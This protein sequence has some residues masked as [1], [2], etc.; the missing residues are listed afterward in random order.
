MVSDDRQS[1]QPNESQTIAIR[2][3][4]QEAAHPGTNVSDV[5]PNHAT[6]NRF[7]IHTLDLLSG[8]TCYADASISSTPPSLSPRQAGLGVFLINSQVQTQQIIYIKALLTGT[9]SVLMAE[10]AAMALAANLAACLN[11]DQVTFLSDSQQLVDFLN[12][13]DAATLQNGRSSTTLKCTK[14]LQQHGR[15][16]SS[17]S[18]GI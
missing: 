4:S 15:P 8:V 13:S 5:G 12:S 17:R 3:S 9:D 7:T 11:Y 2:Q 1:H 10:A 14:I 18:T 16:R 6:M